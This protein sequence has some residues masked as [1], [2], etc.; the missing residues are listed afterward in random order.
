MKIK[1]TDIQW[2]ADNMEDVSDLSTVT[3]IDFPI[4]LLKNEDVNDIQDV[5]EDF[6]SDEI[7]N[8]VGFTHNGWGNSQILFV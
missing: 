8:K 7:S 1:V 4:E 3:I 2:D 5:I 6:I